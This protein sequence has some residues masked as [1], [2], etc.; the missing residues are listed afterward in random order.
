MVLSIVQKF[1]KALTRLH[2]LLQAEEGQML[3]MNTIKKAVVFFLRILTKGVA[4]TIVGNAQS[5]ALTGD[6]SLL[7]K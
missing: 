3:T 1:C 2:G 7:Q 5:I 6:L 4:P